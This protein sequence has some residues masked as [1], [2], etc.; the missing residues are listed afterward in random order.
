MLKQNFSAKLSFCLAHLLVLLETTF[1]HVGV[2]YVSI[3]ICSYWYILL[4]T[5]IYTDL[6]GNVPLWEAIKGGHDSVMKLLID[7]GADISSGDVGSLACISV[8]QNNLE[9]LKDIVQCGG[10]VTRSASNG[11][12]ALHAAVCEGNVEI[13]KF[14]LEHGADIDKQDDSGLTPRILA[15]QQCHEEI[16]NVFKKV[17][18]KKTPHAIPT[19]SFFERYQ[20][21]PTIPGIPQGSKP[22]NEEPTWFD[23]HQRRRVSPFHN[24]FFGIMSNANYGKYSIYLFNLMFFF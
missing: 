8:A 7:N 5:L 4:T 1:F 10:D 22:P 11:S 3:G 2:M 21:E 18:H 6:D 19:T 14:L 20:S 12:T 17:G 15:D 13:V 16:I 9:L 23:N 24:S